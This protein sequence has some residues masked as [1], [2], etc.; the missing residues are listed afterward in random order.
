[1][2]NYNEIADS[3]FLRREQ[4][5]VRKAKRKR[6]LTHVVAS[7][8]SICLTALLCLSILQRE[9]REILPT[10]KP[11]DVLYTASG[12]CDNGNEEETAVSAVEKDKIVIAYTDEPLFGALKLNVDTKLADFVEMDK[13]EINEYYGIN[14]FPAVPDDLQEWDDPNYGIYR[15]SGG[16]GEVYWDQLVVNY[17]SEDFSRGINIEIKK[18]ALP[19]L[20]YC[21]MEV[22]EE[23]SMINHTEVLILSWQPNQYHAV[24]MY[25]NVG[26]C[27]NAKGIT[28]EAFVN[29]ISSLIK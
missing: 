16:T 17:S 26:F 1:M 18:N 9:L 10:Q 4:Y 7:A 3:V 24:F 2:K 5:E 19:L 28:Q 12:Y 14:V 21:F 25:R 29:V 15:R 11:D 23:K 8:C 6:K 20:D 13:A 27:V 22:Q